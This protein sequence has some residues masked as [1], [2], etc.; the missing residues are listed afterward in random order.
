[1]RSSIASLCAALAAL[2]LFSMP[3]IAGVYGAVRG[4]VVD[5]SGHPVAAATVTLRAEDAAPLSAKSAADGTFEFPRVVFDTYTITATASDGRTISDV[6]TVASDGMVAVELKLAQK[7]I[8]RVAV[9]SHTAAPPAGVSV[10]TA[11]TISTLPGNTSLNKV[12]QTVPGV[13]PFS[14]NEPVSRGF[15]GVQY[16]VDGVPLPQTTSSQ[17]AEVIDPRDVDRLEVFTGAIPAEF[18]GERDGAVVDIITNRSPVQTGSR[19]TLSLSTGTYGYGN[20]SMDEAAGSGPF[21][22]YVSANEERTNRGIDSPTFDP[23]HD[24]SSQGDEF[25]RALFTPNARDSYAVDFSN[26]YSGFQIPIDT[27]ATDVNDPCWSPSGTNDYQQE[28]DRSANV[29]F[30]R[31]SEDGKGYFEIAPWYRTGRVTYLPD[32]SN[33][34]AGGCP[35]STFQDRIAK[36][37]GLTTA[38]FRTV[39]KHNIKIGATG[40]VESF[41]SAFSITLCQPSS[42]PCVPQAPFLDDVAQRGSNLGI[43]VEDKFQPSATQSINAGIRYDHSTGFTSG[44]Q[45]S[46]R[47]EFDDEVGPKDTL[48]VYFGRLY[49]APAL[50]DVRRDAVVVSGGGSLPVYDLK[51][52]HDSVFEGGLAHRFSPYTNGSATI[53]FRNV[54]NVLDTTQLGG[55]PIFTLFNS[56]LGRADGLELRVNGVSGDRGDNWFLSYGLSESYANGI[57][58]GTFLFPVSQLQ[59]A[60]GW[61]LEDHDQTN[62]LNSAYTWDYGPGQYFTFQTTW[63]SGFPAQFENGA[64]RLPQHVEI[65]MALGKKAPSNG[66]GFGWEIEGTNLLNKQYLLKLNNGFNTTQ[67]APGRQ[68]TLKLIAPIL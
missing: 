47:F 29:V 52:E 40:D 39:G 11:Q 64:G 54:T 60:N 34:L 49:A 51:P 46:P 66:S 45:I 63:G 50:E 18:G 22:V 43:Y 15:H 41:T 62:T 65:G 20:L 23:I 6:V 58:G 53:W 42:S 7:V 35:A 55:T 67:Y 27:N 57:S 8:G 1:M 2:T 30:N 28:Y 21:R 36:Y 3:A 37:T 9:V 56:A 38:S 68:V 61:A 4:T 24:S 19:G 12:I 59:G 26:Q 17:F 25:L 31:A 5:D 16:E 10:V 14:Y 33:D 32:L 48:H 44:N 13:V